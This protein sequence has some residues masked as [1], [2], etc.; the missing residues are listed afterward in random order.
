VALVGP[1]GSGK[2][3]IA[4]LLLRFYDPELG[5][6]AL[7]GHDLRDVELASLRR[8]VAILLQETLVLHGTVR[9][10][11]A[12]ARPHATDAEIR[13]AAEAAGAT[14]FIEALPQGYDTDLGERGRRLSGGQRQR[15]AIARALLAD[16]PVLVL[17]EPSTGLDAE[18]RTALME[19]LGRLMRDRTTLVISHDLL[20]VRDADEILVLEAGRVAERGTHDELVA[21]G[22]RYAGLWALHDVGD[23]VV[24]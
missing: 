6:V 20:T 8:N 5:T 22:G 14:R 15:V 9:D 7:D 4:K 2:T 3:T 13:A 24:A 16:A 12:F 10:N 11:I 1:S 21:A 19:P 17:D 18:A 23:Q